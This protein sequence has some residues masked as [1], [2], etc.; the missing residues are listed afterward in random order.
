MY[1]E[2]YPRVSNDRWKVITNGYD[3]EDFAGIQ[4]PPPKAASTGQLTLLHSGVLYSSE[5]NPDHFLPH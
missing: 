3:E 4:T 1:A 5:R 2:R